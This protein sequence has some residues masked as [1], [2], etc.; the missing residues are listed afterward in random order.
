M[1]KRRNREQIAKSVYGKYTKEELQNKHGLKSP[2]IQ[3]FH[4]MLDLNKLIKRVTPEQIK[5][6]KEK[7]LNG[8]YGQQ[9]N[10]TMRD[11]L[12][13]SA[14]L[15]KDFKQLPAYLKE[16]FK[17]N[18]F[19][20]HKFLTDNSDNKYALAELQAELSNSD[21]M[22]RFIEKQKFLEKESQKAKDLEQQSL[23]QAIASAIN[24]N[25]DQ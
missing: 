14:K 1:E 11:I 21:S 10:S 17:N 5:A 13:Q 15:Q 19:D 16:H 12:L 7:Q 22:K 4:D 20:Y 25:K 9:D 18:E 23:A 8:N 24:L 3:G 6:L 2:V